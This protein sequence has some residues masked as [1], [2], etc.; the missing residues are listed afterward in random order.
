MKNVFVALACVAISG[1]CALGCH[2]FDPADPLSSA[3]LERAITKVGHSDCQK[4]LDAIEKQVKDCRGK[5]ES[6]STVAGAWSCKPDGGASV[7]VLHIDDKGQTAD[8]LLEAWD[9]M[10]AF[11]EHEKPVASQQFVGGHDGGTF[12]FFSQDPQVD[13]SGQLTRGGSGLAGKVVVRN[14]TNCF[15][16]NYTCHQL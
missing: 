7:T 9:D 4:S 8:G 13:F 10:G 11:Q 2:G 1:T 15:T 5:G 12:V 14:E 6:S 16:D 3:P